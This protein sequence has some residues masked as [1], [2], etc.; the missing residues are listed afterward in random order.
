ML[1]VVTVIVDEPVCP[2]VSVNV[3]TQVPAATPVTVCGSDGPEPVPGLI[4]AI[5]P[6]TGEHVSLS[7]NVPE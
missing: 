3:T 4:V 2:C 6:A 5:V 1:L 7:V